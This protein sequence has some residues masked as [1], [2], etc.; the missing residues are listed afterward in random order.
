V[1]LP[2]KVAWIEQAKRMRE[3]RDEAYRNVFVAKGTDERWVGELGEIVFQAWLDTK[4]VPHE[5]FTDDP[6][7]RADFDVAGSSV[8]VKTVKRVVPVKTS[9]TA[10]ITARHAQEPVEQFF[11]LSYHVPTRSMWLCGGISRA[12]FLA[13]AR[14]HGPGSRVHAN[15]TIRPGHE[16]HNISISRLRSPDDWFERRN[17]GRLVDVAEPVIPP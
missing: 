1:V 11:F 10:Q 14:Y 13:E 3:T 4:K 8:G 2:V 16:I 6:A 7:G 9:F 17:A 5:W 12:R 15:Y